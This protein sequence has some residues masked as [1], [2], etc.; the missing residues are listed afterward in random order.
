MT[1]FGV[2]V[3]WWCEANVDFN[4]YA[5]VDFNENS[6]AVVIGMCLSLAMVFVLVPFVLLFS[7]FLRVRSFPLRRASLS[8]I[9]AHLAVTCATDR[10][11]CSECTNSTS[12][13]GP[14]TVAI[15]CALCDSS[16]ATIMY[17]PIVDFHGHLRRH[18]HASLD[19]RVLDHAQRTHQVTS[20]PPEF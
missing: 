8:T 9:C 3:P 15:S 5:N 18:R 6:H 1:A 19:K 17:T 16:T 12:S 11:L 13:P 4:Y 14:V 2:C 20:W 7:T 10:A